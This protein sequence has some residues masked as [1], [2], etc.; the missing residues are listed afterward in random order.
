MRLLPVV[1]G[2]TP[3]V[4]DVGLIVALEPEGLGVEAPGAAVVAATRAVGGLDLAVQE[5]AF[6]QVE[7]AGSVGAV[8]RDRM[9]GVVRVEA[10]QDQLEPVR[11]AVLVVVDEQR[12]VRFLGEIHA[13]RGELEADR[14]VK[15]LGEHRLL[16]GLA[17]TVGVFE[18][19]ELVVGQ[20]VAGSVVRV[21]RGRRDPEPAAG[22][23]G[24]LHRLL[25]VGELLLG[26][27]EL[28]LEAGRHRHLGD[29]LLAR[30]ERGGIPVL[31][32]G[33]E[34]GGDRG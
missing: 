11:L 21:G 28:D 5:A 26:G 23:E 3:G 30:E 14:Q 16:V 19:Q 2:I 29:G 27:E 4:G 34:V 12:Q 33:L 18:D 9:V 22:V 17:V 31:H 15:V 25:Q 7:G 6:E 32:A 24:H 13:F 10:V 1:E 8:S 20:R